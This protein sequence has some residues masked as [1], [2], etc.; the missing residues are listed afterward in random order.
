M[1]Q[2]K[3]KIYIAPLKHKLSGGTPDLT[4]QNHDRT[5]LFSST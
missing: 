3:S 5:E 1:K 4:T 2:I